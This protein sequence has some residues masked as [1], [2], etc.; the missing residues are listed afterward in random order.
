MR[1]YQLTV[2]STPDE[3]TIDPQSREETVLSDTN[4]GATDQGTHR[5]S[6]RS[7]VF[8]KITETNIVL[9]ITGYSVLFS[10]PISIS[11]TLSCDSFLYSFSFI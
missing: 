3:L 6:V 8:T 4:E 1:R 2:L 9:T 7:Y 10:V 5:S 11:V